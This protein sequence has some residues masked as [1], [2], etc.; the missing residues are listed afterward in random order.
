MC[1][2]PEISQEDYEKLEKVKARELKQKETSKVY[3]DKRNAA[4]KALIANHQPEY[5]AMIA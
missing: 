5:D 3:R 2:P 4:I 1:P